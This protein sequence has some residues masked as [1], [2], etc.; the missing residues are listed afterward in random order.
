MIKNEQNIILLL[1]YLDKSNSIPT[2]G[3]LD[4]TMVSVKL[5]KGNSNIKKRCVITNKNE[6]NNR[7]LYLNKFRLIGRKKISGI[8]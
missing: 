5:F 7:Y 4:I 3:K 8:K 1:T 6:K 2:G